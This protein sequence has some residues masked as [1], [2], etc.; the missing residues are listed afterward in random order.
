MQSSISSPLVGE[1]KG[2]GAS[3]AI[4]RSVCLCVGCNLCWFACA[5][6][7]EAKQPWQGPIAVAALA[8]LAFATSP[9]RRQ[10]LLVIALYVVMGLV[11]DSIQV[12]FGTMSFSTDSPALGVL[13]VW[14]VA[15]WANFGCV[16]EYL[17]V[18]KPYVAGC[19]VLGALFGPAAYA[20]GEHFGALHITRFGLFAISMEWAISFPFMVYVTPPKTKKGAAIVEALAAAGQP[21]ADDANSVPAKQRAAATVLGPAETAPQKRTK[22]DQQ[23]VQ[24][25]GKRR[26]VAALGS[27]PETAGSNISLAPVLRQGL[28][29]K[30]SSTLDKTLVLKD[31]DLMDTSVSEL[32]SIEA[33]D[34]MQECARRLMEKP[35]EGQVYCAWMQR[36]V[37]HHGT[38]IRSYPALRDA[39]RPLHDATSSRCASYRTLM[40]MHGRLH[41]LVS[42]GNEAVRC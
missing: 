38:F 11:L 7:P 4:A 6:S 24:D 27:R 33:Y 39:L 9:S 12:A 35:M 28:R 20:G 18:F 17:V 26:K 36:V 30:D 21:R 8:T 10:L 1:T 22:A 25:A 13:P 14:F 32:S 40:Y 3:M 37:Y 31:R 2:V 34:L 41:G 16:A 29:S 15:L 42:R 19:A 23:A 5:L